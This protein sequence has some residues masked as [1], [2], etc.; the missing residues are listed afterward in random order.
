VW[1]NP[2]YADAVAEPDRPPPEP[3]GE[4]LARIRRHGGEEPVIALDQYE[5]HD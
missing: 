2:K 3:S 5:G 4:V 1:R